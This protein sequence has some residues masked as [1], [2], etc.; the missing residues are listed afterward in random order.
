[1]IE[2]SNQQIQNEEGNLGKNKVDRLSLRDEIRAI[3]KG[4]ETVLWLNRAQNYEK[5]DNGQTVRPMTVY[6]GGGEAPTWDEEVMDM[7]VM[8]QNQ[9]RLKSGR[10]SDVYSVLA[11]PYLGEWK[12]IAHEYAESIKGSKR[13][14]S[15]G[16][17]TDSDF[18]AIDVVNVM[19]ELVGTEPRTFVLEQALTVI[20]TPQLDLKVD[21]YT[22]FT[23]QS[24]VPEGVAPIPKR[25]AVSRTSFDLTKD[26]SMIAIT[27]EA[28]LR[29]I[30]D[31]YKT[32][33]DNAVTDFKRLK[34]NKIATKLNTAS[35]TGTA[36]WAAFTTDHNSTD[37]RQ[38][39][40]GVADAIFANNGA[41]NIIASADKTW[42]TFASSTFIKGV[43]QAVPLPDMSMA[44]IINQVPGLPGFTWYVDN[45]MLNT[46]AAVFD[47]KAV[48]L[49]QGP[50]RT[51]QVRLEQEGID[52]YI[53]RDWNL[54]VFL[55]SNRVALLTSTNA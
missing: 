24:G 21:T 10:T 17:G 42:R 20:G 49:L 8:L 45:E 31:L 55:I 37:P 30:H 12:D 27:D 26:V 50:V 36:D 43:L 53:Y 9:Q 14:K 22:R 46:T 1:M 19:A 33:V 44:K 6:R 15:A 41:P 13:I 38:A 2:M 3:E 11:D 28:Q 51:A 52:G 5:G 4:K 32:Q 48:A 54:P 16:V 7:S 25:G 29:T 23:A 47:R 18:A 34:S 39:I 35:A 40:G